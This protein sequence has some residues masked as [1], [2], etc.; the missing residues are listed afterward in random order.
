VPDAGLAT[1]PAMRHV[2]LLVLVATLTAAAS[3]VLGPG[4]AS[5]LR[6]PAWAQPLTVAGLPNLH[7]VAPGV[8]RGAQPTAGG[9]RELEKLGIKLVINL[10][11]FHDDEDEVE[12]TSLRRAKISFKTWHAEEEDVVRFLKLV[13]DPANQPVF[14]HC[15]HGADRT[16]TMS[17]I[18][19]MAIQ[20]WSSEA[21]VREMIEG[22]YNFHPIWSNLPAYLNAVDVVK[23]RVAAGIT[24]PPALAAP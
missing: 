14:F 19:R 1:L 3:D 22:G 23:L 17:A 21:A 12:G 5:E 2:I 8:Y 16:G 13:N 6:P 11:A 7:L 4:Q 15:Q 9:M 10:R 20:G 18:Y 24:A